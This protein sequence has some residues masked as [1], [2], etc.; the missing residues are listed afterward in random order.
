MSR[1][2]RVFFSTRVTS[3]QRNRAFDG[4][5]H[6]SD[7]PQSHSSPASIDSSERFERDDKKGN[8]A[9]KGLKRTP[10]GVNGFCRRAITIMALLGSFLSV[11]T[12]SAVAAGAAAWSVRAVAEPTNFSTDDTMGCESE[13]KCDRDLR[14]PGHVGGEQQR[15]GN[16]QGPGRG[17]LLSHDISQLIGEHVTLPPV[18]EC[19]PGQRHGESGTSPKHSQNRGKPNNGFLTRHGRTRAARSTRHDN[20]PTARE[21]QTGGN[22]G[23]TAQPGPEGGK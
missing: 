7:C 14:V 1:S 15:D 23:P 9:M 11:S 16:G 18:C 8:G 22:H 5:S 10:R 6:L 17:A 3:K 4:G 19:A 20:Q 12:A 21:T 13:E 2:L